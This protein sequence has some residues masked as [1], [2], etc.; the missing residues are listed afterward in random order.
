MK[1]TLDPAIAAQLGEKTARLIGAGQEL[2]VFGEMDPG[3]AGECG[4]EIC[5][6][7]ARTILSGGAPHRVV[8]LAGESMRTRRAV[9][10]SSDDLEAV[11][12]LEAVVA[13]GS[14]RI[15]LKLASLDAA[16][17]Q[18]PMARLGNL[19]GFA[20]GAVGLIKSIWP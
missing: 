10:L 2:S 12:R 9:A 3:L 13:M 15:G 7:E 20:T 14:S 16:E 17:A 5:S 8:S 1:L 19:I 18:E 4:V 11:S 6:L